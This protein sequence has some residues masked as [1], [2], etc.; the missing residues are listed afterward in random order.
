MDNISK[1]ALA[2]RIYKS[3]KSDDEK[4][5]MLWRLTGLHGLYAEEIILKLRHYVK[6]QYGYELEQFIL[7]TN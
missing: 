7:E 6:S 4:L 1:L 5:T 2:I 3:D